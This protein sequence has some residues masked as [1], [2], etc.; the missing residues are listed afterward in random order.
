MYNLRYRLM[1]SIDSS[2]PCNREFRLMDEVVLTRHFNAPCEPVRE[3][4][5]SAMGALHAH[6]QICEWHATSST[7]ICACQAD[8]HSL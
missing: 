6:R 3:A 1:I 4:S 8:V 7:T 2:L 5:W